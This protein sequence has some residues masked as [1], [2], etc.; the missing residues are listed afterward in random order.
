MQ[1]NNQMISRPGNSGPPW[2]TLLSMVGQVIGFFLSY[3]NEYSQSS[4][5]LF[6]SLHKIHHDRTYVEIVGEQLHMAP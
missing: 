4:K 6:E 3:T 2:F 5:S 1:V